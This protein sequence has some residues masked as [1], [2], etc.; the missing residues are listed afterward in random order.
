MTALSANCP[1]CSAP[2]EFQQGASVVIVCPFCRSA[3]AR[4]D[5][6]LEDLGKVAEIIG[7]PTPLKLGL[8][9]IWRNSKFTL[10]GH[11]QLAHEAG[12]T[13][14]EWYATF[15][16][17]WVG[18]LAEAQ[19]K[20]YLTFHQHLP[21]DTRVP[22][23]D[24]LEIGAAFPLPL[25]NKKFVV[26]EKGTATAVS[27]EGEI[28]F[29]FV[30]NE[31]STYADLS[32]ANDAFA[33]VDYG[34]NPPYVFIGEEVTLDEIGLGAAEFIEKERR[35]ISAERLNCP[36]CAAPLSLNAPDLTERV[37][38]PHCS[39][40]IDTSKGYLK[41]L[42]TLKTSPSGS[43]YLPLGAK[44]SFADGVE[45]KIIGAMVRSVKIDGIKYF[46][47]E[48][49]LYNRTEGFRWLVHSDNHWSFVE[50]INAGDIELE[51]WVKAGRGISG[52]PNKSSIKY[53]GENFRI[54]QDAP[55]TVEYLK[56]E[57]YWRVESGQESRG[58][59]F[60]NAPLMI[61]LECSGNGNSGEDIWTRG[62]YMEVR[63]VEKVFGVKDLPRPWSIAP[64]QPFKYSW[65]YKYG[66]AAALALIFLSGFL[67]ILGGSTTTKTYNLQFPALANPG[68]SAVIFTEPFEIKPNR[69]V[70]IEAYTP[71]QNS[72]A[73]F[74]F[75]LINEANETIESIPINLEYYSG[76]EGGES[77][78][79]GS[80]IDDKFIS[81]LPEGKY[82]LRV[83]G[84][85]QEYRNPLSA[86]V[87]VS[88]GGARGVNFCIAL[89]LIGFLPAITLI[90]HYIFLVRRW[91]ESMFS[92]AS[93]DDSDDSG[94]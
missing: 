68:A 8:K 66:A 82:T 41:F 42:S 87:K 12:G 13:W 49:L 9:G 14:D 26:A 40:L 4:T 52:M 80:T 83:E 23:F 28:P 2:I 36:K 61:S 15:E 10:T 29:R 59:D 3:V 72:Y 47:T 63:E 21:P 90:W 91:K 74:D 71:L 86:Q 89:F 46:F 81:S 39:S 7:T 1:S 64:N 30:P 33:T 55:L 70:A 58:V 75:D 69:N 34:M 43:Y 50:P 24:S 57:F 27:A 38:C 93:N 77:W 60:V 35:K 6:A 44:G 85:W 48:Y 31:R 45:R 94:D 20:F 84:N 16:N 88:Q 79:E 25:N 37:A 76:Y 5:R 54:F 92:P 56:G 17:G 32:G 11:T 67:T 78:S 18:W 65:V 51:S 62:T 22:T 73:E 53:K 19:G